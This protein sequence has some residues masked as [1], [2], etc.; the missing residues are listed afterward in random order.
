MQTNAL[1][2]YDDTDNP[3]GCCPRFNP[4][5]WDGQHL[6]F[7]DKDFVRA[8]TRSDN[9]VPID[10]D[11]VFQKTFGAIMQAG[12]HD[13]NNTIVLSRDVS[14]SQGEH[15]FAVSKPVPGE[16]MVKLTGDYLTKVFEGPYEKQPQWQNQFHAEIEAQGKHV[17]KSY[18]FY[19]TCPTCAAT[20]GKNYVVGVAELTD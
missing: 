1:P 14:P 16:E 11:E 4:K 7:E 19:T 17:G 20:Y 8:V 12:A 18:M 5:G 2:H 10:M 9:H 3:T 6:H 13:P 15:L